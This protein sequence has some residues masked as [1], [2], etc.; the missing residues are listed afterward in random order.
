MGRANFGLRRVKLEKFDKGYFPNKDF[1]EIPDGGSAD[2]KHV[3]WNRSAL[4]KF[5]GMDRINSSQAATTRGNG[6]FELDVNGARLRT[7]VFGNAFYEDVAGTWTSRTGAI[8][9]TDGA[10]N[11]VQAIN[12][13]R[14]ANK[15]AIYVNGVN[16]PWK[17]TGSGNAAALGGSPPANFSS[18]S[19]YHRTIFGSSGES[20]YFSDTDDPETWNASRWVI[21]FNRDITR[22]IDHG[23]KLAVFMDG[24]TGS[25]SGFDYLDFSA[26]H[27]EIKN[28]GSVGRL[29]CSNAT[30][31][32]NDTKVIATVS[33]DGLYLIDEAF[34]YDKIFGNEYFAD[35][36][37]ANLSKAVV[38]YWAAEKLLFIALPK[39]STENDYLI[40]MDMQTG[41]F[42]P[43]PTIHGNSIRSMAVMKDDNSVDYV[44]FVDT[45]GYAFKFNLATKNYH[46]GTATQAVDSRWKSKTYDL[47][48]V[49]SL[50]VPKLLAD[51][52]GDWSVTM[53]VGFGLTANDGNSGTINLQDDSDVLGSSFILGASTLSGSDYVFRV[54]SSVNSFG[55]FMSVTFTNANVDE[56]FHIKRAE[57][58]LKRRRMGGADK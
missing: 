31:G 49:H 48:D 44:Y 16:A 6:V 13:Q 58:D 43:G 32:T 5:P 25:I 36:N 54:L 34:G 56:A 12:H 53:S 23:Q 24:Q 26:E 10:A 8:T 14:G 9:I 21:P 27:E 3:L 46:T 50:R 19:K 15:Y 55:R 7:A 40:I 39:D 35:F 42:W 41:A 20:L 2:C 22:S 47:D 1:D 57:F 28:V 18:I 11:L 38:C 29:S 51:A 52:D 17:W 37:Q 30:F 4:R 33:R 45:N